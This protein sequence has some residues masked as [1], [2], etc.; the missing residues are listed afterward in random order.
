MEN[1]KPIPNFGY[2]LM[3]LF[4]CLIY[5]TT[6]AQWI[7]QGPGPSEFGQVENL[8]TNNEVVGAVNCVT[9]HPSNADILYIGAVNG[10][11]WRTLNATANTPNWEFISADLPSPSIG[12]LEFDPADASN[13][14]LVVG[15]GRTSSFLRLGVGPRGIFRT[16]TGAGPWTNIDP[17]GT[18]SNRNITGIAAQGA[19]I[20]VSTDNGTYRTTNTGTTW[21]LISGAAGTGLPAGIA[22]DLVQDPSTS[23]TIYTNAGTNGIYQSTNMGATWTEIS[24]AAVDGALV[25]AGNVELAVGNANNIFIAI[26]TNRI[27]SSLFRSSNGGANWTSL[28]IPQTTEGPLTMGIHPGRQGNIHLSITADPNDSNVVYIGGDRQPGANETDF[29][30]SQFP[31]SLGA[32]NYTGRLFRVDASLA[33]GSQFT[34]ITHVGTSSNSAPHADSRDMDFDANGELI[35]GDD[36]GVYRQSSPNNASGD[37]SSLN[38]NINV[39]EI[40]SSAWDAVSNIIISGLQDNGVSEQNFST[41]NIWRNRRGGDGGDIAVDDISSAITSTR[42]LSTQFFGRFRRRVYN[43]ANEFQS[44]SNPTLINTAT[45]IGISGF[46]FVNPIKLNSQNGQRLLISTTGGLFESFDQGNTVTA[47]PGLAGAVNNFGQDA[48]AYGASDNVEIIYV[49]S[50]T[51]V[52]IRTTAGG[53]LSNSTNYSGGNVQGVTIDPDDSQSAF[54]IDNDQVFE[55]DDTGSS[56]DDITGNLQSLNPGTLRSIAYIPNSSNDILAVGSDLGVY[57]SPGPNF[58]TW[59][60]LGTNLPIAA[61]YDLEYDGADEILLATTMGRGA[62]TWNFSERDPVDVILALD[63]SGSMLNNACPTCDPKI[64]VLKEAVE[65]FMQLW[66]G[67]AVTDDRIG[68]VYFQTNVSSYGEGSVLFSVIDETDEMIND[69]R[70]KTTISTQ[71]TA[72]GGALQRSINSLTDATRPRNVILFTDGMQNVNPGVVF[73]GLTIENGVYSTNSNVN[74]TNP[75]TDLDDDLNINI[76]TIGVGTT[77]AVESQLEDIAS[78]TEGITKITNAPDEDL[79]RFF[80]EELVD[81][82]RDFSPQLMAY[83]KNTLNGSRSE[84]FNVNATAQEIVFKV[85]YDVGDEV[86]INILKGNE[87]VTRL[88]EITSG[89]FYRIYSFPFERLVLLQDSRFDGAWQINLRSQRATNYEI[90]LIV[91]E[92]TIDY[93]LSVGGPYGVGEP[94][95]LSADILI[96]DFSTIEDITVTASID[97][98]REGL[99]TLLSTIPVTGTAPVSL[100]PNQ[101]LGAQKLARLYQNLDFLSRLRPDNTS[102]TLSP[103]A[104]RVFRASFENTNVPGTYTITYQ[105]SG[106]H[107]L[108]GPFERE[109]K[110][111]VTVRFGSFDFESSDVIINRRLNGESIIWTWNFVPKDDFGNYLGP[112]YADLLQI[113]SSNGNIQNVT[114]NGDGSYSFE[115]VSN[116]GTVPNVKIGLYEETWFDGQIP[117]SRSNRFFLSAH[118]GVGIPRD[119]LDVLVDPSIFGKLDLEYRINNNLSAQLIGGLYSFNSDLNAA[120]GVLQA[121]G[122]LRIPPKL[123]L[124]AEVGPGFYHLYGGIGTRGT[125]GGYD[126]GA[127]IEYQ[128]KPN[129]RLSLGGNWVRLLDHPQDYEWFGIGLGVHIGL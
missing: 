83:R 47:I 102:L 91:D 24:N 34:A 37:W 112:D 2:L 124:F 61:V 46:S 5:T 8:P 22:Y 92:A 88:A 89:R 52:L 93:N 57:I 1:L 67:L 23:N 43:S 110:Q 63:F 99:G 28:D 20:V 111:S 122:Y 36:G 64:E 118:L 16:T 68:V 56:W 45:G 81:V 10:G 78:G 95:Q 29:S 44:Q 79:R 108:T 35:E 114:D 33:T 31:N 65:I 129:F 3:I 7:Q 18:L 104:D 13:Q 66:K 87:N 109:E 115:V 103:G 94:L 19:T 107:P 85:S 113:R 116:A 86:N 4:H 54:V 101:K 96:N 51:N 55:T 60:R 98:P 41:N 38:G 84:V 27:L 32:Q 58:N 76:N 71:W 11:V 117:D 82:L 74:A 97:R 40:H 26:V 48:I 9:P 25:G 80:V 121:K 119:A 127:G 125:Y 120:F 106:T 128:F 90:A 21:N 53:S 50:G 62:W 17:A 69:I 73:P 15:F 12:A 77:P 105:V 42:Y 70:S 6:Q 49:G 100:E 39:S 75:P 30:V 72:M 126:L 14:T 59:A 123:R